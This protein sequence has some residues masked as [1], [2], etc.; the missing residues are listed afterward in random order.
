LIKVISMAI[1]FKN[2][3][4][5]SLG[6]M[7]C[8][9]TISCIVDDEGTLHRVADPPEKKPPSGILREAKARLRTTPPLTARGKM[10]PCRPGFRSPR[11]KEDDHSG[12]H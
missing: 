4:T 10:I 5:L 3:I 1:T 12:L 11:E 2:K 7:F 6:A 9:G 8:F